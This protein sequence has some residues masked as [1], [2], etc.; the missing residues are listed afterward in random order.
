MPPRKRVPTEL[1]FRTATW[2]CP[3]TCG[4]CTHTRDNGLRCKNRVCFGSPVCWLHN[5]KKYGVKI[6]QSTIPG[7]GKGLFATRNIPRDSWICPYSGEAT[8]MD[9]IHQRYPG[10]ATA[11]YAEQVHK[12]LAYDCACSR[13]IGSLS[14]AH[15]N[16]NGTVSAERNHNSFSRYRPKGN[17]VPGV[18]LKS[19]KVIKEG[20]EIFNW[21]GNGGYRLQD[22]HSTSRR[23]KVPDSRPC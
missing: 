7:A 14:N 11:A 4:Q 2:S 6:K 18:W 15:F 3:L 16:P 19:T 10:D 23:P 13:G 20:Q 8:T 1:S 21:Y 9:C 5:A 17:G 12:N 22:N